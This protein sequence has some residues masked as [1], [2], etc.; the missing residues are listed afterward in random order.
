MRVGGCFALNR[1]FFFPIFFDG[2][3]E[4]VWK[5]VVSLVRTCA[6]CKPLVGVRLVVCKFKS[7]VVLSVGDAKSKYEAGR[8]LF[9]RQI[10]SWHFKGRIETTYFAWKFETT[11]KLLK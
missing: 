8:W 11:Y 9:N 2:V 7:G 6:A 3:P 4:G 5:K 1:G 10:V